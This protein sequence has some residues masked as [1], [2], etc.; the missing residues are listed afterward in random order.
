MKYG[1]SDYDRHLATHND[2]RNMEGHAGELLERSIKPSTF[3]PVNVNVVRYIAKNRLGLV[4][5]AWL[6]REFMFD[7]ISRYIK[8]VDRGQDEN[9]LETFTD[10]LSLTLPQ[11]LDCLMFK[12][13]DTMEK[14]KAVVII[15]LARKTWLH[16]KGV[17]DKELKVLQKRLPAVEDDKV[18][19]KA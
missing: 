18:K 19:I 14:Q 7:Y 10:L 2:Y 1:P 13:I 3:A 8:P 17:L 6:R 16:F 9:G 15:I 12:D 5:L 4:L 11:E